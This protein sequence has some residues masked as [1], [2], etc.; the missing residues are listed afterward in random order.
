MAPALLAA[1]P[2][3]ISGVSG[4]AATGINAG[5]TA[6]NNRLQIAENEKAFARNQAAVREQN[7]YNS[8]AQQLA[9]LAA[10]GLS[11][12][13]AYGNG[14]IVSSTQNDVASYDPASLQAPQVDVNSAVASALQVREQFNKNSLAKS[15]SALQSAQAMLATTTNDVTKKDLEFLTDS[16]GFRLGALE[17]NLKILKQQGSINEETI[18]KLKT[19]NKLNLEYLSQEEWNTLAAEGRFDLLMVEL[20]MKREELDQLRTIFPAKLALM[21]SEQALNWA[22]SDEARGYITTFASIIDERRS[23]ARLNNATSSNI[24]AENR[25]W[26]PGLR[27]ERARTQAFGTHTRTT[28]IGAKG[29]S[30]SESSRYYRAR[31]LSDPRYWETGARESYW[32]AGRGLVSTSLPSGSR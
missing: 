9:R 2:S 29:V 19:E 24:E 5:L 13:M 14:D 18:Q 16:Y 22:K 4:L 20:D 12:Q 10:A 30:W 21:S 25:A 32:D 1:L 27:K 11:P 26:S 23:T 28:S 31:G 15:L 3:I 7:M 8:P 17:E 6:R